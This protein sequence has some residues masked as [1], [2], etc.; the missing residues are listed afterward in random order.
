M[1]RRDSLAIP[2]RRSRKGQQA[3]GGPEAADGTNGMS[4]SLADGRS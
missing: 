3:A 2:E 1:G 4:F